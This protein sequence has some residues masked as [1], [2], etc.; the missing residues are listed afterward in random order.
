MGYLPDIVELLPFRVA[1]RREDNVGVFA[2]KLR[3]DTRYYPRMRCL[4]VISTS[5]V[6]DLARNVVVAAEVTV[7][8][9]LCNPPHPGVDSRP[10]LGRRYAPQPLVWIPCC[11]M[12]RVGSRSRVGYVRVDIGILGNVLG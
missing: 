7:L 11:A 1:R 4:G 8:L 6:C 12:D 2:P 10:S 5:K 9:G 3:G